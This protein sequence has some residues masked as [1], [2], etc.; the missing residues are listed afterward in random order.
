MEYPKLTHDEKRNTKLTL[1]EIEQ[2]K[3]NYQRNPNLKLLADEYGVSKRCIRYWVDD[4]W[5]IKQLTENKKRAKIRRME[6]S[7]EKKKLLLQQSYKAKKIRYWKFKKIRIWK[8]EKMQ[9]PEHKKWAREYYQRDE[10]KTKIKIR[11][12]MPEYKLTKKRYRNQPENKI[13]AKDYQKNLRKN[14]DHQKKRKQYMETYVERLRN[15]PEKLAMYLEKKRE[16]QRK[17]RERMRKEK[18]ES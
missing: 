18:N 12:S 11:E 16:R 3:D 17:Y 10:V 15:E 1:I 4:G 14:T 6:E 7:P 9:T 2:I 5:R 13:K 8:S